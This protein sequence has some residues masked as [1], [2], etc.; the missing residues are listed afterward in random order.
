MNETS[1]RVDRLE[2]RQKRLVDSRN[3]DLIKLKSELEISLKLQDSQAKQLQLEVDTAQ[4]VLIPSI[5]ADLRSLEQDLSIAEQTESDDNRTASTELLNQHLALQS[6]AA[7]ISEELQSLSLLIKQRHTATLSELKAVDQDLEAAIGSDNEQNQADFAAQLNRTREI[8]NQLDDAI[9]QSVRHDEEL[10]SESINLSSAVR[11]TGGRAGAETRATRLASVLFRNTEDHAIRADA[12]SIKALKAYEERMYQGLL[13]NLS[14]AAN[15]AAWEDRSLHALLTA[16]VVHQN[17]VL[18]ASRASEQVVFS[19][20]NQS[21]ADTLAAIEQEEGTVNQGNATIAAGIG[22]LDAD[23]AAR[24]TE[25]SAALAELAAQVNA[26][27]AAR[28]SADNESLAV[29]VGLNASFAATAQRLWGS[30]GLLTTDLTTEEAR[31]LADVARSRAEMLANGTALQAAIAAELDNVSAAVGALAHNDDSARAV[32]RAGINSETAALASQAQDIEAS[33]TQDAATLGAELANVTAEQIAADVAANATLLRTQDAQAAAAKA[34]VHAAAA[35]RSRLKKDWEALA[36]ARAAVAVSRAR[37]SAGLSAAIRDAVGAARADLLREVVQG[38][39]TAQAEVEARMADLKRQL[40]ALDTGSTAREGEINAAASAV[41]ARQAAAA[42]RI[43]AAISRLQTAQAALDA[44]QSAFFKVASTGLSGAMAEMEQSVADL[45]RQEEADQ[46]ATA[47]GWAADVEAATGEMARAESGLRSSAAA[48]I[49]TAV[50]SLRTDLVAAA[51]KTADA[52]SVAEQNTSGMVAALPLDFDARERALATLEL[53]LIDADAFGR[54][55]S[56][57][58]AALQRNITSTVEKDNIDM[59]SAETRDIAD[60]EAR[61]AADGNNL[62]SWYGAASARQRG[63]LVAAATAAYGRVDTR[64]DNLTADAD[65]AAARLSAALADEVAR[66]AAAGHVAEEEQARVATGQA[67]LAGNAT[68]KFAALALQVDAARAA[69]ERLRALARKDDGSVSAEVSE[70]LQAGIARARAEA[71]GLASQLDAGINVSAHKALDDWDSRSAALVQRAVSQMDILSGRADEDRAVLSGRVQRQSQAIEALQARQAQLQDAGR[72]GLA[73]VPAAVKAMEAAAGAEAQTLREQQGADARALVGHMNEEMAGWVVNATAAWAK[74]QRQ[75][76]GQFANRSAVI[77]ARVLT[78]EST[79]MARVHAAILSAHDANIAANTNQSGLA[80]RLAALAAKEA[81]DE[82]NAGGKLAELRGQLADLAGRLGLEQTVEEGQ[83]GN[84]ESQ[85][86]L[87]AG[88]YGAR[89]A[90]L[91]G[92]LTAQA[93][94]VAAAGLDMQGGINQLQSQV[95]GLEADV[96]DLQRAIKA[97][98][99]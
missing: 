34:Y 85:T 65:A 2:A 29:L 21:R 90:T 79:D 12:S 13:R 1:A 10:H 56:A 24:N 30:E 51:N 96:A 14:E 61:L 69:L 20:G 95:R 88:S 6:M 19:Q 36:V 73:S 91:Q 54:N 5:T 33:D 25:L 40:E 18:A 63:S 59:R 3:V 42:A 7:H 83:L 16:L 72:A 84:L 78:E 93:T 57:S 37:V 80:A 8:H 17:S 45:A 92:A 98:P 76:R 4:N 39:A 70:T 48:T 52:L 74:L 81:A 35:L 27:R 86:V 87:R 68:E 82:T 9:V 44:H 55:A 94:N 97:A 66:Q 71:L 77:K 64:L 67:A 32:Y 49:E 99:P 58:L 28:I 23:I 47:H 75:L 41:R 43:D 46:E 15:R 62:T 11:A 31:E 38:A 26:L 89:A 53:A 60:A 50:E 22:T